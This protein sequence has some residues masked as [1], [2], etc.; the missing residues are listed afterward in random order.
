VLYGIPE[1]DKVEAK[2]GVLYKLVYGV[3]EDEEEKKDDEVV[4]E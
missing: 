2:K 4:G 3:K 1:P